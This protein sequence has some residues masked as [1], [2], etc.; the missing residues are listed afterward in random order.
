[1]I[2]KRSKILDFKQRTKT[3]QK[4]SLK[5]TALL[6]PGPLS[7]FL[8]VN[9]YKYISNNYN[10]SRSES[11]FLKIASKRREHICDSPLLEENRLNKAK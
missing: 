4:R 2:N 1:M 5:Q 9:H 7:L 10:L 8:R 3:W 6:F 11:L